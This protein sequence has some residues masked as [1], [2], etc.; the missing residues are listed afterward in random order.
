MPKVFCN[1][2][3][4]YSKKIPIE[5][6]EKV[7]KCTLNIQKNKFNPNME[8]LEYLFK[9]YHEYLSQY[10]TQ[11]IDCSACRAKVFGI[12]LQIIKIWK[13]TT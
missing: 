6:R 9:I 3:E 13:V 2:L 1:M 11:K 7:L 5:K 12:F 4:I 8:D 10:N